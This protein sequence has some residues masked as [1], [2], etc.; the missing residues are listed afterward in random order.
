MTASRQFRDFP[1]ALT[2]PLFGGPFSIE[3]MESLSSDGAVGMFGSSKIYEVYIK[4]LST[5]R[6]VAWFL[7]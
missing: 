2:T 3:S 1:P 4:K 6:R 5:L 7:K